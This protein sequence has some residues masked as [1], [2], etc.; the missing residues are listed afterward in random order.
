MI[1]KETELFRE[2]TGIMS[3][4]MAQVPVESEIID[5]N[6][7][8]VQRAMAS[9][10]PVFRVSNERNQES[11]FFVGQTTIAGQDPISIHC[12]LYG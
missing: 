4:M 9:G 12:E 11:L 1:K 3:G 2:E 6:F 5:P 7:A 10:M 8:F